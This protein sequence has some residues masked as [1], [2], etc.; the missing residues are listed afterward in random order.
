MPL[1]STPCKSR[2]T[3]S[4]SQKK[5]NGLLDCIKNRMEI[6]TNLLHH[7]VTGWYILSEMLYTKLH[8]TDLKKHKGEIERG[9]KND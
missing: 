8:S 3:G 1:W 6:N 9:N 4:S 2:T 5:V 7:R